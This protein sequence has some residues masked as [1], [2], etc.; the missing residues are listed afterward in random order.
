MSSL[1]DE[2]RRK[3]RSLPREERVRLGE[4]LLASVQ[5]TGKEI[6]AAWS[7]EIQRRLDEVEGGTAKLVPAKE[8]FGH[9]RDLLK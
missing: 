9:L 7:G 4:E 5:D 2:L 3:A 1:N 8:V 6:D